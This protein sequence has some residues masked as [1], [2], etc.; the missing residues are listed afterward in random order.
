MGLAQVD[1]RLESARARGIIVPGVQLVIV[2]VGQLEHT[3]LEPRSSSNVYFTGWEK[4]RPRCS[5]TKA[6]SSASAPANSSGAVVDVVA[7]L[8]DE[9]PPVVVAVVSGDEPS[10]SMTT[11]PTALPRMSAA[12]ATTRARNTMRLRKQVI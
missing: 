9:E 6:W 11:R 3:G 2:L 10:S 5:T 12:T 1:T 7:P 4:A 8:V